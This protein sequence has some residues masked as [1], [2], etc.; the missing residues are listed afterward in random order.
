MGRDFF[1]AERIGMRCWA[2]GCVFGC[3]LGFTLAGQNEEK[4]LF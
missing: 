1:R 4:K 3:R 2:T